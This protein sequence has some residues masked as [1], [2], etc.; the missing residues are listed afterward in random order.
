LSLP[1]SYEPIIMAL[2][3]RADELTFDTFAGRLLQES[4]RRQVAQVRQPDMG[5]NTSSG[6]AFTAKY[7]MRGRN[8]GGGYG[9]WRGGMRTPMA[10]GVARSDTPGTNLKG[11]GT[12]KVK[13]KC[14]YC[15]KEGHW[16]RNCFRRKADEGKEASPTTGRDQGGLAFTVLD[17]EMPGHHSEIG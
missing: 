12:S 15:Q 4:A 1:D 5:Q 10:F 14:F 17:S 13:G 3:S 11:V 6:G 7:P 16:K 8:I 9:L 2:Q